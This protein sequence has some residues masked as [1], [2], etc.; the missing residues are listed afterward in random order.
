MEAFW[1]DVKFAVRMLLRSPGFAVVA[2]LTLALGIG[3]N[4]ALFSLVN[5]ILLAPLRFPQADRLVAL[6]QHKPE[7]EYSSISYP[8]FLDWQR[9]NQT[10]QSLAAFRPTDFSL[11]GLGEPQRID[12]I[13]VSANFFPTLGLNP[14]L[15]GEFD[16]QQDV[17]G[18]KPEVMIS[19]GM[20]KTQFGSTP[21]VVGRPLTLNGTAYTI[22]G[23]VPVS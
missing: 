11:T 15:G 5:G 20:W 22:V 2:I 10:L 13:M 18:G 3:A 21:D 16:P 19:A 12:G 1:S 23:V 7:F 4:T 17:L 14:V 8:N 6:Y 9:D